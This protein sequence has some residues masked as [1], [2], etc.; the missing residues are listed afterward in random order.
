MVGKKV[1]KHLTCFSFT[2]FGRSGDRIGK[3]AYDGDTEKTRK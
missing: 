2:A 3:E 1:L